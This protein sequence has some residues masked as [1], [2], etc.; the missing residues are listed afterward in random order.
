MEIYGD[1]RVYKDGLR[2]LLSEYPVTSETR[3]DSC[4]AAR[5]YVLSGMNLTRIHRLLVRYPPPHFSVLIVSPRYFQLIHLMLPGLVKLLL[6]E[7]VRPHAL[8][9]DL[10]CTSRYR[11]SSSPAP[12]SAPARHYRLT[13]AQTWVFRL[14]IAGCNMAEMASVLHIS[15]KTCAAHR[16][17]MLRKI[18]IRSLQ[19]LHALRHTI[20]IPSSLPSPA[21]VSREIVT[22]GAG[23]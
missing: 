7:T 3:Q 6:P 23:T 5:I 13:P 22:E 1:N 18:G 9:R 2:Q 15:Q 16:G 12:V 21:Q 11:Q 19:D 17:K 20:E 10:A 4:P 14:I 8:L